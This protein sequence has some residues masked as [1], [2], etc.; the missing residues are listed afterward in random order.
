MINIITHTHKQTFKNNKIREKNIKTDVDDDEDNKLKN[1]FLFI[2]II[3][4]FFFL[5]KNI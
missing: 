4:Y 1:R 3:F 2:N 5:N